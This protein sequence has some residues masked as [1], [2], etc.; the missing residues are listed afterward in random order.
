MK[1]PTIKID[2][3]EY[4]VK[5]TIGK[6][7]RLQNELELANLDEVMNS[8]A[9]KPH[10]LAVAASIGTGLDYNQI[11]DSDIPITKLLQAVIAAFNLAFW[12]EGG[13]PPLP[14]ASPGATPGLTEPPE[15]AG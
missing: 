5:F 1:L 12:G 6:L 15:N 8:I 3:K 4:P 7:E 9:Q 14:Q 2:G 10:N 11:A 13:A